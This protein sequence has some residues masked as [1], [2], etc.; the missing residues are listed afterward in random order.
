MEI[1]IVSDIHDNLK[2]LNTLLDICEA[3]EIQHLICCGDLCSPFVIGALGESNLNCYIVFGNND[4]DKF[5]MLRLAEQYKN[6]R[7]FG[8]YIGDEE[9]P[10][11]LDGVRFG[12]TH[13]PFYAQTMVKTGWFDAVFFGHSHSFHKQKFGKSLLLNP[14]EVAGIFNEASFAVYDTEFRG[15]EKVKIG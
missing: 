10:L 7:L 9:N 15:C 2:N 1:A 3:R 13:Y 4:S 12:V 8:D 5:N 11:I 6:L 14:G